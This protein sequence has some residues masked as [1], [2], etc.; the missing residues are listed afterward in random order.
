MNESDNNIMRVLVT[1]ADGLLGSNLVRLL[2]KRKYD[3]SVFLHPSSKST[4]LDGLNIHKYFG[5]I[6]DISSYDN[7]I[8]DTDAVI[9]M[10][11][12]TS[13]WPARSEY[14]NR[15]NI[16]GT[17][18]IVKLA[19][20]HKTKR[21]IYIG[22]ASSVNST[23]NTNGDSY[24][25]AKFG[26]DY[27]DSKYHALRSVMDAV[28]NNGLA[29]LAILPTFMIGAYDSLPSSGRMILS[30]AKKQLKFYSKGG[31]NIVYVNDVATAIANSLTMGEIG[32][33]YIAGNEN[34]TYKSF[35][36]KI[37]KVIGQEAPKIG[38]PNWAI[39]S[40]G[41]LGNLYGNVL[42]KQP[43]ISYPMALISCEKQFTDSSAAI[44][45]IGMP[46]TPIEKAIKECHEWF[47]AN[48][49]CEKT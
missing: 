3:V 23:N 32:Q 8:K 47:K 10:A 22:S 30:I 39:K 5:D 35:F 24:P 41:Y 38:I 25:G 42:N 33:Y 16:E 48:G 11:A 2:L 29:A 46:Q 17:E 14:V 40:I 34:L 26:L 20:K 28:K 4:T 37:A 18:N 49:Y 36:I 31:R 6:L 21:F 27:I 15:V 45:D 1:G 43:L 44:Q 19:L 12:I 7:L 13:I 9:H